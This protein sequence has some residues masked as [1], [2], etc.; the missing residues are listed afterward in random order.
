MHFYF[1][2]VYITV[3]S[4]FLIPSQTMLARFWYPIAQISTICLVM[5]SRF[6]HKIEHELHPLSP[7]KKSYFYIKNPLLSFSITSEH[8]LSAHFRFPVFIPSISY[9]PTISTHRK[10][11]QVIKAMV[12]IIFYKQIP[13][14]PFFILTRF[15]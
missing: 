7:A 9:C 15:P 13:Q 4:A 3:H 5:L 1:V 10:P 8:F 14:F 2:P 12:P 6:P 11:S